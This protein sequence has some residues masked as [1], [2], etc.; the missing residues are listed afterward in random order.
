MKLVINACYGGFSLSPKAIK[1]LAELNGRE[2]YFF[3]SKYLGAGKAKYVKIE[4]PVKSTLFFTAFSVPNPDEYIKSDKDWREMTSEERQDSN[5]RYQ[6]INLD[7]RPDDR[8]D[9]KLIQVVEELGE[10]ASGACAKLKIVEI[11]DGI[12]YEIDE[13]DGLESV[14]EKHRSW[15]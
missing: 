12:D 1:R 11:P 4:E 5:N 8:A 7:S 13:Y 15:N 3:E 14:E 6:E 2:C 10:E 9:P